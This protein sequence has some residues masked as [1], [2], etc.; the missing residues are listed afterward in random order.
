MVVMA[1][2]VP[3]TASAAC[4]PRPGVN[5]SAGSSR[6][7]V[8]KVEEEVEETTTM[9][10]RSPS[11]SRS[12]VSSSPDAVCPVGTTMR[13]RRY[14][15]ARVTRSVRENLRCLRL[16]TSRSQP[17]VCC[18]TAARGIMLG[19]RRGCWPRSPRHRCAAQIEL[20]SIP[21]IFASDSTHPSPGDGL[22]RLAPTYSSHPVSA[23]SCIRWLE[24]CRL[25]GLSVMRMTGICQAA[26]PPASAIRRTRLRYP[27]VGWL[28]SPAGLAAPPGPDLALLFVEPAPQSSTSSF[29]RRA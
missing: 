1:V 12:R 26:P 27:V 29:S 23:L 21:S 5:E 8:G 19:F 10:G 9:P 25:A 15:R 22:W 18:W 17:P 7:C 13:T 6:F 14:V 3:C 24:H 11:V 20:L 4:P 2:L 28:V 16:S